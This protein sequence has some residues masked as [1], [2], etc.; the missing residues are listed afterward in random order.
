MKRRLIR[1]NKNQQS[2]ALHTYGTPVKPADL[3]VYG[4]WP[5]TTVH[6]R[7]YYRRKAKRRERKWT[8]HN[9]ESGT[10]TAFLRGE[11]N[12]I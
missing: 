2:T 6:T 8:Q 10:I 3:R 7:L 4:H 1:H 12:Q 11:I 5:E 9:I